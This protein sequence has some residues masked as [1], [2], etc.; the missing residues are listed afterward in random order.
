MVTTPLERDLAALNRGTEALVRH[1]QVHLEPV[2]RGMAMFEER[3]APYAQMA[4]EAQAQLAKE[5]EPVVRVMRAAEYQLG[6]VVQAF[7]D[8]ER[9]RE[10]ALRALAEPA[11]LPR[12]PSLPVSPLVGYIPLDL[13]P[14]SETDQRL[15]SIENRLKNIEKVWGWANQGVLRRRPWSRG[16]LGNR[17]AVIRSRP[18]TK[19]AQLAIRK[20][21]SNVRWHC[22]SSR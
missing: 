16:F 15:Q 2:V 12:A 5:L 13:D 19:P 3:M 11:R 7:L 1:L 18:I 20:E 8:S 10:L 4:A 6:P 9:K 21:T 22:N 14:V 17:M